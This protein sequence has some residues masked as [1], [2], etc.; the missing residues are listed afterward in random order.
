LFVYLR[1][2]YFQFITEI[3]IE[4]V[5]MFQYC[6]VHYYRLVSQKFFFFSQCY[7]VLA[8]IMLLTCTSLIIMVT[9]LSL[10]GRSFVT[11]NNTINKRACF[12][13]GT[14]ESNK[15]CYINLALF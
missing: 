7:I 8:Q 11:A 3:K 14:F 4:N 9:S 5:S 6:F 1:S 2:F 13:A 10:I 15:Q 12:G